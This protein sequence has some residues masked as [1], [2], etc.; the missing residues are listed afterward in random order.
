[1]DAGEW[2]LPR[3]AEVGSVVVAGVAIVLGIV[4]RLAPEDE[5]FETVRFVFQLIGLGCA[6]VAIAVGLTTM[7]RGRLGASVLPES[8]R[9]DR[10][11]R[12][13]IGAA[14]VGRVEPPSGTDGLVRSTA[15]RVVTLMRTSVLTVTGMLVL[16]ASALAQRSDGDAWRWLFLLAAV[17]FAVALVASLWQYHGALRVLARSEPAPADE[18]R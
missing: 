10:R 11:T 2:P 9:L 17:M 3:W 16:E 1:M 4:L 13:R 12:R 6:S 5:P 18:V 8:R 14:A 7:A 15:K